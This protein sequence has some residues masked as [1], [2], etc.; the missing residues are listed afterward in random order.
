MPRWHN[1]VMVALVN[2]FY[3]TL[4]NFFVTIGG[5]LLISDSEQK[6]RHKSFG[7]EIPF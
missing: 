7:D 2:F 6:V 1:F 4:V 3:P 5:N